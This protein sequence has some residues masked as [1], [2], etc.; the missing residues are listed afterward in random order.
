MQCGINDTDLW[1]Q[2]FNLTLNV[3][4]TKF[5]VF[6]TSQRLSAYTDMTKK[7]KGSNNSNT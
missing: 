3:K 4:Q 5:M 7:V 1:L 2:E 6:G